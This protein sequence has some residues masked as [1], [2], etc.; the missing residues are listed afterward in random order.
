[1][2]ASFD[3]TFPAP[4]NESTFFAAAERD[5]TN[6]RDIA[7]A[8]T[9]IEC[10]KEYHWGPVWLVNPKPVFAVG[11]PQF[12]KVDSRGRIGFPFSRL[13]AGSEFADLADRLNAV[14]PSL[15][16]QVEDVDKKSK[17][18]QLSA[19]FKDPEQVREFFKVWYWFSERGRH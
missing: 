17:G 1:M 7:L 8:R 6:P 2:F 11:N 19:L 12:F 10:A 5:A 16:I 4:W 15:H 3:E 13:R 9:V 14:V 18:G